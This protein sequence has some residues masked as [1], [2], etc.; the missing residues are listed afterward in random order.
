MVAR[1]LHRL[2]EHLVVLRGAGGVEVEGLRGRREADLVGLLEDEEP[3]G[4]GH[5]HDQ[6]LRLHLGLVLEQDRH[7]VLGGLLDHLVAELDVR[8]Q[9][10][11]RALDVLRDA[12]AVVR[13]L[14]QARGLPD[15]V[16][17]HHRHH[18]LRELR[19][20]HAGAED[21]VVAR[22]GQLVRPARADDEG[23]AVLVE[24]L[25]L[26]RAYRRVVLAGRA[27]HLVL[28]DQLLGHGGAGGRPAL[29][30]LHDQLDLLAEQAAGGVDVVHRPLEPQHQLRTL[31]V[32]ARRRERRQA[33][34][35]DGVG[36]PRGDPRQ[37]Q[38]RRDGG[39]RQRLHVA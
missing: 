36:R 10:L 18:V 29:G 11:D 12:H 19:G 28:G 27:H 24:D 14:D 23:D 31:L 8:V 6:D 33:A 15:A 13:V 26:G 30:V 2:P 5:R 25:D 35:L 3:A 4:L 16:G 1:V 34:D 32:A 37:R 17:H 22:G 21:F 39:P 20:I 7:E 9:L 38:R